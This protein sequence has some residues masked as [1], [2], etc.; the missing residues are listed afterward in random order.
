[1]KKELTKVCT[2]CGKNK[3]I[4]DFHKC[5]IGKYGV[6]SWCK[7][8]MAEYHK[9]RRKEN[10]EHLNAQNRE[11]YNRNRK[12][13]AEYAKQYYLE[14]KEAY[15]LRKKYY[16]E[17]NKEKI[18]EAAKKYQHTHREFLAANSAKYRALK[19]KQ[20]PELAQ[21]ELNL[22]K[23]YYKI[24]QVMGE[25]YHVDHVVPI[26]KGGLHHPNNLQ[27]CHKDDNFSKN[28]KLCYIYRHPRYVVGVGS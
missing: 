23:L 8:C 13:K 25:N 21:Q 16:M 17:N 10:K 7:Q 2:K 6:C 15:R 22:I 28:D 27:I 24:S 26:N 18:K 19:L 11:Y 9:L 5:K 12:N 1:M 20:T 4:T 3:P 14:N